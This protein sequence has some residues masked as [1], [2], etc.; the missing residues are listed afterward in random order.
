MGVSAVIRDPEV[1]VDPGRDARRQVVLRNTG[2]TV[3]QFTLAVRGEP[4]GW[5]RIQ[6]DSVNLLPNEE[7]VAEL[8]F[9][10]PRSAAVLAGDYPYAVQVVSRED[11]GGSAVHEGTVSVAAFTSVDA[12]LVPRTARARVR[13]RTTLAVDNLGNHRTA[14]GLL[15]YDQDDL[16]VFKY[17][18]RTVSTEPGT[19]TFVRVKPAPRKYFWRGN[20][21]AIP[22]Q[23]DVR[24]EGGQPLV[25]D[26]V[27]VQRP[28]L[29]KRTFMILPLLLVLL[30]IGAMLLAT[31]RQQTPESEAG[32]SPLIQPTSTPSTSLPA[33]NTPTPSSAIVSSSTG[34][35]TA[36]VPGSGSGSGS[37]SPAS[38]TVASVSI[39]AQAGAGIPGTYQMFGYVV[40]AGHPLSVVSVQLRDNGSDQG[41]AEIRTPDG[42]V[43]LA[44]DLSSLGEYDYRF[45]NPVPVQ[46]GEQITLA[47]DCHNATNACAPVATFAVGPNG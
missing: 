9:A 31:L 7:T 34:P 5:S 4:E 45:G 17:R 16:L 25:V 42:V 24:P 46:P 40:P 15:G 33:T 37:G 32:H 38:G 43:A 18:P 28:L 12:Q 13:G 3:D 35:A 2:A 19:A 6:P 8:V 22:Y 21:R 10:P 44:R 41:T 23:L 36:A 29:P 11:A 26:G 27:L 47:V 14:V 30:L 20:D 39:A 1:A